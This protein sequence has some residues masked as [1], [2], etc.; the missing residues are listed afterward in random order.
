LPAALEAGGQ[1][2]P[3]THSPSLTA[4]MFAND[5]RLAAIDGQKAT[6]TA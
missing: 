3:R 1:R 6:I 5:S 2:N 4:N